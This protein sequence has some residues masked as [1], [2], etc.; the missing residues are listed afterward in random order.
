MRITFTAC[1]IFLLAFLL[2]QKAS[3]QTAEQQRRVS[4]EKIRKLRQTELNVL[5]GEGRFTMDYEGWIN[6]RYDNYSDDDND[7][8]TSDAL[9]YTHS[10]DTR[11]WI[12]GALKPPA[13]ASYPNEHSFY[14]RFKNLY[15]KRQP[16]DQKGAYDND[17]PH[18]DYAYLVLDI[19]PVWMEIGRRYYSVGQGLAYSNVNDG[20]ELLLATTNWNIKSFVSHTLPR[21]D[22]IDTS[23]P[24]YSRKSERTFYAVEATYLGIPDQGVY[25]YYLRQR[26]DSDP[27]PPDPFH[28]YT[29]D[30]EYAGLGLQ[31]KVIANMH[32]WA[33]LIRQTGESRVFDTGEKR[34]V[35]AWAA[36]VGIT[37]DLDFYSK[38][39]ISV[40]Y[41][42]GSGDSDRISVTD[43]QNGNIRG[44]DNNFLY[45]GYLPAG[46]ALSPR[47]SNL[48]F[49]KAGVL[50][51][52]LERYNAFRN[53][54]L[55]LDY[56]KY[57][58]DKNLGGI[59]DVDAT[60]NNSDIGSEIDVNF[61]WEILSDLSISF[62]Y[63]RFK[64]GDAYPDSNNDIEEY[65]SFDTTF[66]F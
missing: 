8:S 52:P 27:D 3:A 47:L 28:K 5:K 4:E 58:K 24:G 41:A 59:S 14:I 30:S 45:F 39:N 21:E 23:V 34:D 19:R 48:H 16:E 36:D 17:G 2:P 42:Y 6:Y 61:T 13:G 49:I 9:D 44:D 22:N 10:I 26:D 55:G 32:Y 38:P 54:S 66:T 43:T 57:F 11:F 18:L 60:E 7:S 20:I 56:Y 62:Q 64:P 51:K 1:I 33:E 35:D 25:A 53:F 46:Y 65:F 63:G 12:R 37:Y 15:I 31:G 50:L 29:Y 40:E